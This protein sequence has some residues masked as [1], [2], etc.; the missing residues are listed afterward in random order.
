MF[1]H[2]FYSPFALLRYCNILLGSARAVTWLPNS[3]CRDLGLVGNLSTLGG[4]IVQAQLDN[5]VLGNVFLFVNSN[6]MDIHCQS[7]RPISL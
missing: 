5:C 2:F 6:S 1:Q 7:R 3:R 4:S